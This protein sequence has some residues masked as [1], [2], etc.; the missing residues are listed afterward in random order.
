[1]TSLEHAKALTAVGKFADALRTLDSAPPNR[2]MGRGADVLRAELLERVGRLGQSRVLTEGLL[3]ARDLGAADRAAVELTV[4]RLD[5]EDGNRDT[6]I[7]HIQRSAA[8]AVQAGDLERECWSQIRLVS[9]LSD[10][11]GPDA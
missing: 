10:R 8:L 11:S 3:K 7:T 5:W 6:A 2:G 1:M 4:G 9:I